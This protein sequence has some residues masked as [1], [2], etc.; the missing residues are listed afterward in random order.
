MCVYVC[1]CGLVDEKRNVLKDLE[2]IM[3]ENEIIVTAVSCGL[4]T[5]EQEEK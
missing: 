4:Y 1:V 2:V 3:D 5:E